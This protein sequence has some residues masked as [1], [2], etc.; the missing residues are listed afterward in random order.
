[1]Q[2]RQTIVILDDED[3]IL[4]LYLAFLLP[5]GASVAEAVNSGP[6]G[7]VVESGPWTGVRF[8]AARSGEELAL[9]ARKSLARGERIA[10]GFFDLR[11][12]D[13]MSGLDAVREIRAIDPFA[14]ATVV[15]GHRAT[16]VEEIRE[17]F[18]PAHGDEWDYLNKP[19][20]R[21]EIVQKCRQMLSS[22]SRR[23]REEEHLDEI[24]RLNGRLET[25]GR[26][27]E[28]TVQERTTELGIA[29]DQLAGRNRRLE[30]VLDQLSRTQSRMLQHEKMASIFSLA[31]GVSH[32]ARRDS[33]WSQVGVT[34][35]FLVRGT[36]TMDS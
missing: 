28:K 11:L 32:M 17:I 10:G 21:G 16:S 23:R 1:M 26:D 9:A 20:T 19:F 36:K 2:A 33:S 4:E 5:Q 14:L 24:K 27:L 25:W 6:N 8:I 13:G 3:S 15:T 7:V 29:N 22:W 31:T 12:R 35:R 18:E 34:A 30:D